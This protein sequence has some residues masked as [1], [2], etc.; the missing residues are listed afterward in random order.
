M[1]QIAERL[2][3]FKESVYIL[4]GAVAVLLAVMLV[5]NPMNYYLI[6]SLLHVGQ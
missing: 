3:E 5:I 1:K 4:V 2:Q 6:T